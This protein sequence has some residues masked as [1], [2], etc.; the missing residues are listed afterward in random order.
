MH[1][2]HFAAIVLRHFLQSIHFDSYVLHTTP[3]LQIAAVVCVHNL[4]LAAENG[5][6]DRQAKLKE[7]GL[8]QILGQLKHTSDHSL[9]EK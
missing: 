4:S 7:V 9:A 3:K 5:A 1:L 2:T 8:Y 6:P